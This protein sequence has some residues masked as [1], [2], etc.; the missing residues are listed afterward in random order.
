MKSWPYALQWRERR[1]PPDERVEDVFRRLVVLLASL[2][3]LLVREVAVRLVRGIDFRDQFLRAPVA[4]PAG[5]LTGGGYVRSTCFFSI[6]SV[7]AF[8]SFV[9]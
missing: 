2:H 7:M 1:R 4:G 9:V 8:L 3:V 5:A 6:L